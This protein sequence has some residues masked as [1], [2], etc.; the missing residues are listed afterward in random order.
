MKK[1]DF[2]IDTR[3]QGWRRGRRRRRKGRGR[4]RRYEGGFGCAEVNGDLIDFRSGKKEKKREGKEKVVHT[5]RQTNRQTDRQTDE[6]SGRNQET[7][8]EIEQG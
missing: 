8:I 6:V 7:K 1:H 4:R 3:G 5:H 2:L